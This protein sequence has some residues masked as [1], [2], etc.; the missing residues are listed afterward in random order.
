MV[1]WGPSQNNQRYAFTPLLDDSEDD[2][3]EMEDVLYSTENGAIYKELKS[4]NS[5]KTTSKVDKQSSITAELD[6][7]EQ[8]IPTSLAEALIDDEEEK[9]QR[10]LEAS[11]ML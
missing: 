8:N 9:Q 10:Q 1:L 11:K 6:W 7:I 3:D 2:N 5:S 4:R